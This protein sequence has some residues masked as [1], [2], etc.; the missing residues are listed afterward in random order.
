[1]SE[2]EVIRTG[3]DLALSHGAVALAAFVAG[4]ATAMIYLGLHGG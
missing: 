3:C 1:M 2:V 4:F